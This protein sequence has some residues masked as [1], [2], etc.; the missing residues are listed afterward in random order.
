MAYRLQV[1][2]AALEELRLRQAG[3]GCC[4]ACL[5][6]LADGVKLAAE[7]ID[8]GKALQ[9]LEKLIELSNK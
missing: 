3:D 4:A 7:L 6:L 2:I 1:S 5:V 8:S 9:T